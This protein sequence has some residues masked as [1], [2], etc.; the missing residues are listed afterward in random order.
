M[1]FKRIDKQEPV[2]Y[3]VPESY[4]REVLKKNYEDV[5]VL[6]SNWKVGEQVNATFA[7]YERIEWSSGL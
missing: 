7:T 4:I 5:E 1:K 3:E 6:I 2:E